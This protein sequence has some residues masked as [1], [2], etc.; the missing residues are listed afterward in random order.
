MIL[1]RIS[2]YSTPDGAGGLSAPGRWHLRGRR[3]VHCA[4]NP[5]TALLE[6]LVH[7][8][9]DVDDVPANFRYLEIDA[10]TRWLSRMWTRRRLAGPGRP[11]WRRPAA[12]AMS[13]SAPAAP[14][15]SA[16]LR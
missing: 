15:F 2:N 6:V 16:F 5:A 4:P 9:V 10:P 13:G 8:R 14:P 11:A 3:I 1:W 12:P 7:T